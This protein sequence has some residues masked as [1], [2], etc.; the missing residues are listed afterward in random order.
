MGG[1]FLMGELPLYLVNKDTHRLWHG[2]T[3]QGIQGYLAHEKAPPPP[4]NHHRTPGIGLL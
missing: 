3:R 4:N 1:R 2:P